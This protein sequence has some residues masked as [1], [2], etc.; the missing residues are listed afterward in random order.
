MGKVKVAVVQAASVLF[1]K[2]ASIEKACQ[3][4]K[5]TGNE[6]TNIVLLPEAF[7]P[8]YPRGFTFGMK[9]GNRSEE[10]RELWK[11]YWDNSIETSGHELKKLGKAA[12]EAGIY[13]RY[14]E[15]WFFWR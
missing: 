13:W 2:A 3:L 9:I 14:R 1:D 12:K 11:R 6:G 7:V 15:G 4:I 8:A 10:G 5:E